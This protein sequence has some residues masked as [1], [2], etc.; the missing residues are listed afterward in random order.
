MDSAI[1]L[2]AAQENLD[3]S[4]RSLENRLCPPTALAS[5]IHPSLAPLNERIQNIIVQAL[6][7]GHHITADEAGIAAVLIDPAG[8]R[9]THVVDLANS[10][11]AH[12]EGRIRGSQGSWVGVPGA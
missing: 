2:F 4:G 5:L 1:Q 10:P 11:D 12:S 8:H 9:F 7:P 6:E 3:P